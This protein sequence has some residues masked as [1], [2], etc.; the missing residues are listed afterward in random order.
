MYRSLL[1]ITIII[2]YISA[3]TA[4]ECTK[5]IDVIG[6]AAQ[7]NGLVMPIERE[8]AIF[9]HHLRIVPFEIINSDAKFYIEDRGEPMVRLFTMKN[10][11]TGLQ[12]MIPRD[13]LV[14]M[15]LRGTSV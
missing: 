9:L 7:N 13:F 1:L 2:S 3:A 15:G 6:I 8:H 11:C 10:G 4:D 5:L 14:L 12:W